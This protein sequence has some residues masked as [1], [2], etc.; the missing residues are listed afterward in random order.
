MTTLQAAHVGKNHASAQVSAISADPQ[1]AW[2]CCPSA[3]TPVVACLLVLPGRQLNG[4]G[5]K[6]VIESPVRCDHWNG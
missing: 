2:N 1:S 3:G 4:C 5:L 6:L